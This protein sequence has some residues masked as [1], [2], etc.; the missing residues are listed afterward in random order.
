MRAKQKL[1]NFYMLGVLVVAGLVG[2]AADSWFV[3]F[4]VA[5]VLWAAAINS[6]EI[7]R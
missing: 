2:G 1:N 3:F 7:R 4:V 6:G 5:A